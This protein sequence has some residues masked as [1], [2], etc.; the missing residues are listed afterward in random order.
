[1]SIP[2]GVNASTKASKPSAEP[3]LADVTNLGSIAQMDYAVMA[4]AVRPYRPGDMVPAALAAIERSP[5][6]Y[7]AVGAFVLK[8]ALLVNFLAPLPGVLEYRR[9]EVVDVKSG[10]LV[11]PR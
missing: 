8:E 7:R 1:M 10:Q 3:E 5:A 9:G 4:G 11:P 2:V 6:D